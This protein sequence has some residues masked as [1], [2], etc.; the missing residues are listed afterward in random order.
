MLTILY[1]M[2]K[3]DQVENPINKT[4]KNNDSKKRNKINT[5]SATI[6]TLG[7]PNYI[8]ISFYSLSYL[9]SQ[10]QTVDPAN[11]KKKKKM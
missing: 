11:N 5:S 8:D 3:H 6:G 10:T 7:H 1:K 9:A 4:Q 2:P